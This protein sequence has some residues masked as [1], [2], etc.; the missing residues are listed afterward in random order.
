MPLHLV[1]LCVGVSEIGQ[2][3]DFQARRLAETGR[4]AH[5]TRMVPRRAT[6]ILDG[7]SLYW[8]IGGYIRVRQRILAIE[9]FTDSRGIRRCRLELAP[10]L[11]PVEARRMRAFQG[12]RYL[13]A[14]DA[15]PDLPR[16]GAAGGG[17]ERPPAAM[18]RALRELCLL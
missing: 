10:R 7:G 2:L 4:N 16:A 17:E 15:P 6:E 8:V 13:S 12:W 5:V 11:V 18:E 1:K 14:A 9:P 3:A